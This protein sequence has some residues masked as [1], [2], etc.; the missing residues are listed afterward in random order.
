M[1]RDKTWEIP[2]KPLASAGS[3][4][5]LSFLHGL[6]PGNSSGRLLECSPPPGCSLPALPC[7]SPQ[8]CQTLSLLY[9]MVTELM[10]VRQIRF[11]IL[12]ICL[13]GDYGHLPC[14]LSL[15]PTAIQLGTV[16]E[17][18]ACVALLLSSS[19]ASLSCLVS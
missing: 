17:T 6:W 1:A 12:A 13:P 11:L 14:L 3:T 10:L 15:C 19:L 4:L 8:S 7:S 9:S 2:A 5:A 18:T 16:P